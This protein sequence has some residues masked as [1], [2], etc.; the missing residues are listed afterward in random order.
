MPRTRKI[1]ATHGGEVAHKLL[2]ALE[3]E[4]LVARFVDSYI[5]EF[6]RQCLK[7]DPVYH[8]ELLVTLRRETLLAM[9]GKV[10]AE[11]PRYLTHRRPALLRGAEVQVADAFGEV[12]LASLARALQWAPVDAEEFRRDLNLYAQLAARTQTVKKRRKAEDPPQ[13]PFVDRCALLLDASMLEKARL[14]AGKF[15]MDL[16][17]RTDKILTTVLSYRRV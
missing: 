9:V 5:K 2:N 1:F 13:G 15:L 14:A 12:L 11:L 10:N 17:H 6:D 8:R 4:R 7:T 16:E 3:S